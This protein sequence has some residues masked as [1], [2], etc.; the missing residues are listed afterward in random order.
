[1]HIHMIMSGD[2]TKNKLAQTPWYSVPQKQQ[3]VWCIQK[4]SQLLKSQSCISIK[5]LAGKM[6]IWADKIKTKQYLTNLTI[7]ENNKSVQK[8]IK[9]KEENIL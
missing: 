5:M 1:M 8:L 3:A 7:S 2:S 9:V 6:W 4:V